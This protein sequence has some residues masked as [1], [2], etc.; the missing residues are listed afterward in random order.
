[1]LAN[2]GLRKLHGIHSGFTSQRSPRV[3]GTDLVLFALGGDQPAVGKPSTADE[4]WA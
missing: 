3:F 2:L 1:M 4:I